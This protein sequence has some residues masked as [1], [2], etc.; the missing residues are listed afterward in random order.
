MTTLLEEI[1]Q[2]VKE[3]YLLDRQRVIREAIE[4]L[5]CFLLFLGAIILMY[6]ID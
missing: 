1:E 3:A 4:V 2:A 5:V 6:S